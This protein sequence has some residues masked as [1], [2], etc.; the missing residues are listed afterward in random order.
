LGLFF[1][2]EI[3]SE[4]TK[5]TLTG[6]ARRPDPLQPAPAQR[7]PSG[8]GSRGRPGHAAAAPRQACWARQARPPR[9]YK[10]GAVRALARLPPAQDRWPPSAAAR[11]GHRG[12][13]P[14]P[15][16]RFRL[17]PLLSS[18][19]EHQSLVPTTSS[20]FSPPRSS[21]RMP[22]PLVICPSRTAAT[23]C[24]YRT[25]VGDEGRPVCI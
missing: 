22:G 19:G 25:E 23:P 24:R 3:N 13:P 18:A 21:Q 7:S 14:P 15:L 16:L 17:L 2:L 8:P 9:P 20:S 4:K 10:V 11:P 5:P 1:A 6:R 12:R